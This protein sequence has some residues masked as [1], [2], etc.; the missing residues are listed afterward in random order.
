MKWLKKVA[1]YLLKLVGIAL[2]V[3][4]TVEEIKDITKDKKNESHRRTSKKN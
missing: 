1:K 4:E 2:T 3:N